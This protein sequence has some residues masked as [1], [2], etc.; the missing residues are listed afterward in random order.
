M[1]TLTIG[2]T[3]EVAASVSSSYALREVPFESIVTPKL[4]GPI[5]PYQFLPDYQFVASSS[6]LQRL[7]GLRNTRII[8]A[9]YLHW[10]SSEPGEIA[11]LWRSIWMKRDF[12]GCKVVWA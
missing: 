12:H 2:S 1:H 8:I 11:D 9:D 7:E 5:D 4:Y 3:R 6:A 10:H